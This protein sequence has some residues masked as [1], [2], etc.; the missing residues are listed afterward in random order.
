MRANLA[1]DDRGERVK[2]NLLCWLDYWLATVIENSCFME[3][4]HV[5]DRTTWTWEGQDTKI[6]APSL[7]EWMLL[8]EVNVY[9]NDYSHS[10][11][12]D[13]RASEVL[14]EPYNL[15]HDSRDHRHYIYCNIIK[16]CN[17]KKKL[18]FPYCIIMNIKQPY[19]RRW[20]CHLWICLTGGHTRNIVLILK[21]PRS[22]MHS[23]SH[24]THRILSKK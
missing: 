11:L 15:D 17:L 8:E 4:W 18:P 9:R 3:V 2:K 5:Q 7:L 10:T 1:K 19:Y 21:S 14:D 6:T 16:K 23:Y 13:N 24:E 22:G 12:G 20:I